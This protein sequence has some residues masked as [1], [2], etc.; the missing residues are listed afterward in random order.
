MRKALPMAPRARLPKGA[1]IYDGPSRFNGDRIVAILTGLRRKS[2]NGKTGDMVQLWVMS[3]R[4]DPVTASRLGLDE[5]G[6][7]DCPQRHSLLGWCYVVISQAVLAIW[8]KWR[9]GGYED[10]TSSF[11]PGLLSGRS[12]RA[13]AYGEVTALPDQA[14]RRLLSVKWALVTGYTHQWD[15]EGLQWL[16]GWLMASVDDPEQKATAKALGWRTF[17]AGGELDLQGDEIECANE[18]HGV[19][20]VECGMCNGQR[21]LVEKSI[22]LQTHGTWASWNGRVN[23]D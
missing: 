21:G 10:W 18:T 20:C 15:Q 22:R 23:G 3:A 14:I 5:A 19:T 1:V 16:R 9:R 2:A 7:G 17:R 11:P 8:K 4:K 13:S 12:L 6:C